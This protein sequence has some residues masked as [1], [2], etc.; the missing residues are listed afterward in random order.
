MGEPEAGRGSRAW[1]SGTALAVLVFG[2]ALAS[3]FG[4]QWGSGARNHVPWPQLAPATASDPLERLIPLADTL[5][6]SARRVARS[7]QI[8]AVWLLGDGARALLDDPTRPFHTNPCYPA[9]DARTLGHP[10]FTHALLGLPAWLA[11]GDPVATYN[12]VLVAIAGI[13]AIAMFLLVSEWT[14]SPAA[15][16]VAGL[17]YSFGASRLGLAAY[18][19]LFDTS[20]T[21]LALW[22]TRRA[23]ASG[24]WIDALGAG[25]CCALQIALSFYAVLAGAFLALPLLTWLVVRYGFRELKGVQVLAAIGIVVLAA[26]AVFSPYLA[27]SGA[28]PEAGEVVKIYAP[29]SGLLPGRYL[30]W[31]AFALAVLGVALPQRAPNGDPRLALLAGALLVAFLV[32][33]GNVWAQR[34]AEQAG[35]TPPPALPNL[36]ALLAGWLPGLSAVRGAAATACGI[37]LVVSILAGFGA[38][39]AI[40][41]APPGW[42]QAAAVGLVV[43]AWLSVLR[44]DLLGGSRA[45]DS[46]PARPPAERLAFFED[47]EKQGNS[48]PVL[49]LPI[50]LGST[51]YL[52]VDSASQ[53]LTSAYHHRRTS[54]CYNAKHPPELKQIEALSRRLPEPRAIAALREMGFTTIV[55]HRPPGSPFEARL[56]SAAVPGGPLRRLHATETRTA[57]GIDP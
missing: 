55:V 25:L 47:L 19:F 21:V 12:F 41:L 17:L 35:E 49:E 9:D 44:P 24:R 18:P 2:A 31:T 32:T 7:D 54:G 52:A 3:L 5:R 34:L 33:G 20:W 27:M 38:A 50:D 16:I 22:F 29:W 13:A 57:F 40:R 23:F 26:V 37:H 10:A 36:Y 30:G 1:V 53:T 8:F 43:V 39:A 14:A 15:G 6:S 28:A 56:A 48:G 4:P 45:F 11:T 51:D 42:R 46:L